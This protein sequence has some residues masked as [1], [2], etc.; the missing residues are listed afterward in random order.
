M[1]PNQTL[2][3]IRP[4]RIWE[5]LDLALLVVRHYPVTIGLT[6]LIGIAPW[7]L[8]SL[9]PLVN[10]PTQADEST[11]EGFLFMYFLVFLPLFI[12]IFEPLATAP[13]SLVMGE[14]MLGRRPRFGSITASLFRAVPSFLLMML[15]RA[16][17]LATV[18]GSLLVPINLFYANEVI[19]LERSKLFSFWKR[20]GILTQDAQSYHLWIALVEWGF[21]F[22]FAF[23][24]CGFGLGSLWVTLFGSG[25][26]PL[27][28]EELDL[29]GE[30]PMIAITM[31]MWV[32]VGFFSVA[33]FLF[34][35]DRRTRLEAWDLNL[36]L[37][38]L[39][40]ASGAERGTTP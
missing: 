38:T 16:F 40:I 21:L 2:V 8:F 34:Y 29:L 6:V 30:A 19:L 33:R 18:V 10:E 5:I 24:C 4:R 39:A 7:A 3:R 14:L 31:G 35:I 1:D 17:L 22:G 13:M 26:P 36:K 12:A 27:F 9:I 20:T 28:D 37:Q 11:F 32:A 23:L 25:T 15:L